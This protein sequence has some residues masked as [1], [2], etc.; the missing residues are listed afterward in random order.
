MLIM[1]LAHAR[2]SG[3]GS[4]IN[5]HVCTHIC[6]HSTG[7]DISVVQPIER[8]GK[9]SHQQYLDSDETLSTIQDFSS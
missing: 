4:L 2:A 1:S 5:L 8:V 9:L 6:I 3:D 7:T